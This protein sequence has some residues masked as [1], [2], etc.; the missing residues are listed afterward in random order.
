MMAAALLA[1]TGPGLAGDAAPISVERIRGYLIYEDTGK[2]SADIGG[3][4]DQIV[5]NDE[6]GTSMQLLVDVVVAGPKSYLIEGD[7]PFLRVWAIDASLE[8]P[9]RTL[10]ELTW[11]MSFVGHTGTVIRTLVV[12]H[13]CA[14]VDIVARIDTADGTPGPETTHRFDLMCGD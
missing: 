10:A 7:Q 6:N 3:R 5:A 13:N 2:L 9:G 8:D 12:D 1:A 11:P 14:P 4:T